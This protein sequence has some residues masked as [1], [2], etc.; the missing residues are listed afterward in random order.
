LQA[1]S[2][3]INN[4]DLNILQFIR[5]IKRLWT[6]PTTKVS[7]LNTITGI[8]RAGQDFA[9]FATERAPPPSLAP[10]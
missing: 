5:L 2:A 10:M 3:A 1:I 7:A 9:C 8:L 6:L 4:P